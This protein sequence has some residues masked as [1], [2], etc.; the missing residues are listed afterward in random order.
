MPHTAVNVRY[1]EVCKTDQNQC[2]NT[3]AGVSQNQVDVCPGIGVSPDILVDAHSKPADDDQQQLYGG[4]G[5]KRPE[6][7]YGHTVGGSECQEVVES[8]DQQKTTDVKKQKNGTA[9]S[10]AVQ[11]KSDE[12]FYKHM[13]SFFFIYSKKV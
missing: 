2:A 8:I 6:N 5:Q 4:I 13:Q 9:L 7:V 12:I 10:P 1:K 11:E 3:A